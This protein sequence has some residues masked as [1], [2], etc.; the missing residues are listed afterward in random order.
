[1][2]TQP[3]GLTTLARCWVSPQQ[4]RELPGWGTSSVPGGLLLARPGPTLTVR[5][6]FP[7]AIGPALAVADCQGSGPEEMTF[8]SGDRIEILG[9]Q[10]PGLPW[11]LG[12]H[13]ASGQVGFVQTSLIGVQ[14]QASE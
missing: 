5:G 13:A 11:C 10:V 3:C 9:A 4:S 7:T 8:R 14:G 6:L 1:M 12:R 2:D